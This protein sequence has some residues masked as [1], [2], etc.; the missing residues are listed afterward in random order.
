MQQTGGAWS[1]P[2]DDVFIHFDYAR[3]AAEGHP[4][5]WFAGN[6]YSSGNTSLLYPFVLAAGY[7]AG[8]HGAL[9][10][11]WAAIVAMTSTFMALLAA[12][13]LVVR[14]L[15]GPTAMATSFL[16]PPVVLALGALGWSLW[17]GMEVAFLLGVWALGAAALFPGRRR[18][19]ERRAHRARMVA[20]RDGRRARRDAAR[21]C[22]DGRWVRRRCGARASSVRS[23]AIR[24][25][26][27]SGRS[28]G[29]RARAPVGGQSRSDGRGE[30]ERRHRQARSQQ[31]VPLRRREDR[32]LHPEPSLRHLP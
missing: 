14:S 11:K 32:R 3:A 20:R 13:A 29:P 26:P 31:P 17:S 5:E 4:F 23:R 30:R 2:L 28:G 16:V 18:A 15:P 24:Y 19:H 1:A 7:V 27:P 9:L 10:M 22:H 12:R 6:G 25:A 8:F 21:G